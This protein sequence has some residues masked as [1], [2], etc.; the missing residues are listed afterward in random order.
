MEIKEKN[1]YEGWDCYLDE[2]D[3][4]KT[5]I[6]HKG[7]THEQLKQQILDN[8]RDAK[9]LREFKG[10]SILDIKQGQKLIKLVEDDNKK[11]APYQ[12]IHPSKDYD[13]FHY[14]K[15]LLEQSKGEKE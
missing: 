12:D 15:N 10:V 13:I 7:K 2:A 4:N 11:Y 6:Y 14:T 5:Q 9:T 3:N 8:Q 1:I